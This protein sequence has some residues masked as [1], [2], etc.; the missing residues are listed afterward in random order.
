MPSIVDIFISSISSASGCC[1]DVETSFKSLKKGLNNK[2][3][4][5]L[6]DKD[7][8]LI[9]ETMYEETRKYPELNKLWGKYTDIL[10]YNDKKVRHLI[11]KMLVE[12]DAEKNKVCPHRVLELLFENEKM[13]KMVDE[14]NIF[15]QAALQVKQLCPDHLCYL[16]GDNKQG[17]EFRKLLGNDIEN[18]YGFFNSTTSEKSSR[19]IE[20][21]LIDVG[22]SRS[23]LHKIDDCDIVLNFKEFKRIHSNV[24]LD[25]VQEGHLEIVYNHSRPILDRDTCNYETLIKNYKKGRVKKEIFLDNLY[26]MMLDVEKRKELLDHLK[27]S[28]NKFFSTFNRLKFNGNC[29]YGVIPNEI[30]ALYTA[31]SYPSMKIKQRFGE[32]YFKY[33]DSSLF[34]ICDPK[35]CYQPCDKSSHHSWDGK[36]CEIIGHLRERSENRE[37]QTLYMD[38][39]LSIKDRHEEITYINIFFPGSGLESEFISFNLE[40]I[41]NT[42]TSSTIVDFFFSIKEYHIICYNDVKMIKKFKEIFTDVFRHDRGTNFPCTKIIGLVK[43]LNSLVKAT[44]EECSIPRHFPRTWKDAY[45]KNESNDNSQNNDSEEEEV[46]SDDETSI[47]KQQ[48]THIRKMSKNMEFRNLCYLT[49]GYDYDESESEPYSFWHRKPLRSQQRQEMLTR[50]VAIYE[51]AVSINNAMSKEPEF[52]GH[53]MPI[54][55]ARVGNS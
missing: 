53:N 15:L 32:S 50:L 7:I 14:K 13:V 4:S 28:I 40:K 26:D 46:Q 54:L 23:R 52:R 29:D 47:T 42:H 38:I 6:D 36:A 19:C 3:K 43:R 12:K 49:T 22:I 11:V 24:D 16:G 2:E 45:Y 44:G 30:T 39:K 41:G 55:S 33:E 10:K 51:I 20:A 21:V 8:K 9:V 48:R 25:A 1:K 27:K 5:K 34:R 35:K 31:D 37:F 18:K 17:K